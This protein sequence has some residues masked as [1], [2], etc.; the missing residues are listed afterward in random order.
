MVEFIAF[1][2]EIY[3]EELFYVNTE[4]KRSSELKKNMF[5]GDCLC[6]KKIS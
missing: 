3:T 2:V 4:K 1:G 6:S 5:T